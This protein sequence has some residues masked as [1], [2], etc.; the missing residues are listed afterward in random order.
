MKVK[1]IKIIWRDSKRYIYQMENDEK[2]SVATIET[3]GWLWKI[4]K[5]SY[6]IAQD[7]L[8]DSDVRGV[9]VIPKENIIKIIYLKTNKDTHGTQ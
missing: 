1:P 9:I 7:I 4:E 5:D 8:D 2:V 3:M 6:I